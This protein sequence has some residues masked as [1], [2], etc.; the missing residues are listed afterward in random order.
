M[1]LEYILLFFYF[2]SEEEARLTELEN[3]IKNIKWD[4]IGLSEIRRNFETIREKKDTQTIFCHGKAING[5]GG[6]GF[7][8]KNK[9]K[10]QIEEFK[11]INER[12]AIL[13]LDLNDKYKIKIIQI[14]A[15][16]SESSQQ[17]TETFHE[18]LEDVLTEMPKHKTQIIL[19]GD[20]N[21]KIGEKNSR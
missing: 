20:F 2:Y 19:M 11:T 15:P 9:Y 21:A 6:V 5:Q 4:I 13:R 1:F 10:N 14:Y 8:M 18:N 12:I 3:A 16:T 7:L 17:E